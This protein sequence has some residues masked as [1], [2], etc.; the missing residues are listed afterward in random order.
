MAQRANGLQAAGSRSGVDPVHD[1]AEL[2][3][4]LPVPGTYVHL[5]ARLG[6]N[7]HKS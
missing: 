4:E 2:A 7:K 1:R 6:A 5:P 3:G